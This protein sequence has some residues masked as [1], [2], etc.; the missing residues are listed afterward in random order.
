MH[1]SIVMVIALGGLGGHNPAENLGQ[2]LPTVSPL[3]TPYTNPLPQYNAPS[4]Y[5]VY[6]AKASAYASRA[7]VYE[8]PEYT[9]HWARSAP[10]CGA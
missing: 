6:Y 5:S 3:P 10:H 8:S 1:G 4:S 9:T 2:A 7:G